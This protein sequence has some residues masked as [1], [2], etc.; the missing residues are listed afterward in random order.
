MVVSWLVLELNSRV[1]GMV[2]SGLA[3]T[4]E[5]AEDGFTWIAKRRLEMKWIRRPFIF[6]QA[7]ER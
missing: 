6:A 5:P 4:I 7:A 3:A 2:N 1:D